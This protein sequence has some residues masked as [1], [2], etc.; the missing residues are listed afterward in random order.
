MDVSAL[1]NTPLF[2]DVPDEALTKVATFLYL[3]SIWN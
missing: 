2:A 1:K 3:E